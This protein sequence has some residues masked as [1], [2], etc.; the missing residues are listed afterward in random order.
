MKIELHKGTYS[1][2]SLNFE[3]DGVPFLITGTRHD[4]RHKIYLVDVKNLNTGK[5]KEL[6]HQRLC[7]IIL[8][9]QESS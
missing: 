9:S 3:V 4:E 2:D 6:E 8:R 7:R 1:M 5:T